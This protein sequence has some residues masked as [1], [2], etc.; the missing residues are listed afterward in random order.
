MMV[1][2]FASIMPGG[3]PEWSVWVAMLVCLGIGSGFGFAAKKWVRVGVLFTGFLMGSFIGMAI[4]NSFV[5]KMSKDN[6]LLGL[7]LTIMLTALI[8]A[9]LCMLF[10]DNA[11]IIGSSIAGSYLLFRGISVFAGGYPNE[12]LIYTDYTNDKITEMPVSF[13][14]YTAVISVTAVVALIFQSK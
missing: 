12:F 4:F 10:F 8:V 7:W 14:I 1:L 3:T 11:I 5:F 6:P 2:L 13:M 9:A